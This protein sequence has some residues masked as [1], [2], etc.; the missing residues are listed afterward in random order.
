M[1]DTVLITAMLINDP[2]WSSFI[3]LYVSHPFSSC[4]TWKMWSLEDLGNHQKASK[5]KQ[6]HT[7]RW[8]TENS[9]EQPSFHAQLGKR[10][11]QAQRENSAFIP[12][13]SPWSSDAIPSF[14]KY[15]DEFSCCNRCSPDSTTLQRNG[16]RRAYGLLNP[17][18]ESYSRLCDI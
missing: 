4:T 5:V 3:L 6:I 15:Y 10:K 17:Q 16:T 9:M 14:D 11:S 7:R 12:V 18:G 13:M 2:S 1:L 8:E